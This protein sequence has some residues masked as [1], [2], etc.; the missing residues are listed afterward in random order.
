MLNIELMSELPFG[1]EKVAG[2]GGR[3]DHWRR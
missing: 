2:L 3:Q 1:N